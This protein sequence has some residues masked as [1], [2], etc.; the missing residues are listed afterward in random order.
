MLAE[1]L[2]NHEPLHKEAAQ[3]HIDALKSI[4]AAVIIADNKIHKDEIEQFLSGIEALNISPLIKEED[5]KTWL[6]DNISEID[7][8]LHGSN[9][10]SWLALQFL[11]MR[12]YPHKDVVLDYLWRIA[13][14]DGELHVNEA[15]IIDKA[16]WLWTKE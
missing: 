2:Q 8:M 11:K 14:A 5:T 1:R 16:V 6:Q 13:V 4:L 9:R 3:H 15:A 12:D 10:K 7:T